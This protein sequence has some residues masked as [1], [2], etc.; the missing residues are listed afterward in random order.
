MSINNVEQF[1]R[2][3]AGLDSK[4]KGAVFAAI[5]EC[6]RIELLVRAERGNNGYRDWRVRVTQWMADHIEYPLAGVRTPQRTASSLEQGIV[7]GRKES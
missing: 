5:R 6:D 4:V 7:R 2:D 1:E 3:T